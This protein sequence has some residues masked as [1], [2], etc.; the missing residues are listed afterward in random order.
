MFSDAP[1]LV[2]E[3]NLYIALDLSIAI[4]EMCGCVVGPAAS[5]GES[6]RLLATHRI[7]GAIV[8]CYLGNRE[9]TPLVRQ[10]AER[11]IPFVIHTDVP[12][13]A[14]MSSAAPL[15][16]ILLKPLQPQAV[17][18]CLLAEMRKIVDPQLTESSSLCI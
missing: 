2:A 18:T 9:A 11:S 15:V 13:S 12:V 17:L 3:D 6:L 10:L 7:R 5:I 1:I 16:P 4:E 8:D 14:A